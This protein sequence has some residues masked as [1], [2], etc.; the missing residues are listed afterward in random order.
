MP[1]TLWWYSAKPAQRGK[2]QAP[3]TSGA[4]H[5]RIFN[6]K[7]VELP[8]GLWKE[9]KAQIEQNKDKSQAPPFIPRGSATPVGT[10]KK[11]E[12]TSFAN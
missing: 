7:Q 6:S 9:T 10:D 8:P 11:L 3:K 12:L 5:A 2:G 4:C 1:V